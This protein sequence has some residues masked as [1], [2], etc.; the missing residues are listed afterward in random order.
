MR[1]PLPGPCDLQLVVN[2]SDKRV[3]NELSLPSI[4]NDFGVLLPVWSLS[5]DIES[6]DLS[7]V[8]LQN[9]LR[10]NDLIFGSHDPHRVGDVPCGAEVRHVGLLTGFTVLLIWAEP[11]CSRLANLGQVSAGRN[12]QHFR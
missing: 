7:R 3:S 8:M 9:R 5:S 6:L 1:A 10:D 4:G 11:I 2:G 12:E